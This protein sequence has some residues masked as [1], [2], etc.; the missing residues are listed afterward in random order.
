MIEIQ[1]KSAPRLVVI[2]LVGMLLTAGLVALAS[3]GGSGKPS[4]GSTY[5]TNL[6]DRLHSSSCEH[7]IV[8]PEN[9]IP[10]DSWNATS[11]ADTYA[12]GIKA[13]SGGACP[14]PIT[15]YG[16]EGG[17]FISLGHYWLP[18]E[19]WY[20]DMARN[21]EMRDSYFTMYMW[22]NQSA[23]RYDEIF[24]L[25]PSFDRKHAGAETLE[26]SNM[27]NGVFTN[28]NIPPG[29]N[30]GNVECMSIPG[31][32]FQSLKNTLEDPSVSEYVGIARFPKG[33]IQEGEIFD[34][35]KVLNRWPVPGATVFMFVDRT[36]SGRYYGRMS[37]WLI[38]QTPLGKKS[39]TVGGTGVNYFWDMANIKKEGAAATHVFRADPAYVF[40]LPSVWA[41][42]CNC[43]GPSGSCG[44]KGNA[45]E[46]RFPAV[47]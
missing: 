35:Y 21:H 24:F 12:K 7:P 28:V 13:G 31:Q 9:V 16:G 15:T 17:N 22:S 26:S 6:G 29:G 1:E 45:A 27:F 3:T 36:P 23:W 18:Q 20:D 33:Y 40:G 42:N 5:A 14:I 2:A 32:K 39:N 44:V 43:L 34:V 30:G 10:I 41:K 25:N 38:M 11:D 47:D 8:P 46:M 19:H 37:T 4:T